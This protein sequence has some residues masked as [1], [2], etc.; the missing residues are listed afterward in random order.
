MKILHAATVIIESAEPVCRLVTLVSR[1][2]RLTKIKGGVRSVCSVQ[3]AEPDDD[4]RFE[5]VRPR[6]TVPA[7]QVNVNNA[8]TFQLMITHEWQLDIVP[9]RIG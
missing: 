6:R 1:V 2:E 9:V 4:G 3:E 7:V 8:R 5:Q